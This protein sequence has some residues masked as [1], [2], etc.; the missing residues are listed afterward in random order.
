MLDD[1]SGAA[2][3]GRRSQYSRQPL[4]IL[5]LAGLGIQAELPASQ[6]GATHRANASACFK[7]RLRQDDET[8][9]STLL[10]CLCTCLTTRAVQELVIQA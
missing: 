7:R 10:C 4:Q 1:V 5:T 2:R 6:A 9:H 8:W 3:H